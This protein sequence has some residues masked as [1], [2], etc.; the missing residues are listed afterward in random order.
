VLAE[1]AHESGSAVK[2]RL[3][4]A[5]RKFDRSRSSTIGGL[6]LTG[7]SADAAILFMILAILI[8]WYTIID[9]G[10]HDNWLPFIRPQ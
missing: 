2:A 6:R 5:I 7:I 9:P 10:L 1:N 4:S 8:L 3:Y